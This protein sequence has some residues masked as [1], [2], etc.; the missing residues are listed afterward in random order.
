MEDILKKP[1]FS[2][3][4]AASIAREHFGIFGIATQLPSERDQNFKITSKAS[5]FVIKISNPDVSVNVLALENAAIQI[6][7]GLADTEPHAF[8]VPKLTRT[9]AGSTIVAVQ[10]GAKQICQVRCISFLKGVPL[11]DFKPHS[12]ALLRELGRQLGSLDKSLAA[13]NSS[14]AAQRD[15][16]WDLLNAAEIVKR[17]G[18]NFEDAEKRALLGTFLSHYQKIESRISSLPRSV[19][20]NDANDYNVLVYQDEV[21]NQAL[22]SLIDFGDVLFSHTVFDLAICAAYVIL[23]KQEPVEAMCELV[24]GYHESSRLSELELSVL[25]PL[26]CMRLCQSVCLASEQHAQQ[27]DNEYLCISEGPAWAALEVVSTLNVSTV[28]SSLSRACGGVTAKNTSGGSLDSVDIERLRGKYIAPSLSLA[29]EKP[30]HL[31]RGSGQYLFDPSDVTYLDCVNNVC[32]V[33]HCR[34]EVVD[35]AA[36][37]MGQIN[38]NTRYLHENIVRYGERLA[39]TLPD[40]LDVCYFVNSGSEANDLAVRLAR[41]FRGHQDFVVIDHAYHG[42]ASSL[43]DLSPYKFARSGGAGKPPGT[44]VVPI[45]DGYRGTYKSHEPECGEA[46]AAMARQVLEVATSGGRTIAGCLAESIL[47]CGGQVPLPVGYLERLYANVRQAGGVCIADEVQIGFGRV[48]SHFWGFQQHNVVPDIVTMGKPIGNGHPLG[49][50]VT[51]REIADA[52][53]NG[54]EYFNTFGGNPVSCAVGM[55]V[56]DVIE[57]EQLQQRAAKIGNWLLAQL[58]ELKVQFPCIGDVRGSGLFLGIELVLDHHHLLPATDLA[59]AVVERMKERRVLLSTD[60]PYGNVIKFKP[61]MVFTEGDA[62]R[63]VT[64]LRETFDELG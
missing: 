53:D 38:T 41:A 24:A 45:P 10:S 61:P 19:I 60:G 46:Y 29:Y 4:D 57:K 47:G 39:S 7:G 9:K 27:P 21:T 22:I 20:H 12:P 40:G 6:A 5:E 18:P 37:Q 31:V 58:G 11:A 25:F 2:L 56:L 23:G 32:H 15:L 59:N 44:H 43:I 16:Q 54:M 1:S 30:L 14:V 26:I 51:T 36:L 28:H 13:L 8:E 55:A 49:A 17:I 52:F 63:L 62:E 34:P 42:H 50:V 64:T 3:D 33:G 48:G 35:A